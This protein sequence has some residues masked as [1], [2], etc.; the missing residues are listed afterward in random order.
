MLPVSVLILE[1]RLIE[2]MIWLLSSELNRIKGTGI[3]DPEFLLSAIDF[4]ANYVD[5]CHHGKEE[6]ILFNHL[7]EKP[8]SPE[9]QKIVRELV[10]EHGA[11]RGQVAQLAD[12]RAKFCGGDYGVITGITGALQ[13]LVELY[14]RHIEKE[15]KHFFL[16]S[17][18]YFT[19]EEKSAMLGEFDEFDKNLFKE[20]YLKLVGSQEMSFK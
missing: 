2:R 1:H 10:G 13:A 8:L 5:R 12:L 7:A 16:S 6:Q 17:M 20:R 18:E 14:P 3:P 15:D 4:L 9:H 19:A 11:A